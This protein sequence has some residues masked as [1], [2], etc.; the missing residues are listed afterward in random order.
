LGYL[1]NNKHLLPPSNTRTSADAASLQQAPVPSP[2][3]IDDSPVN[4]WSKEHN[5]YEGLSNFAQRPFSLD[6]VLIARI[7]SEIPNP[8]IRSA[9]TSYLREKGNAVTVNAVE[10]LFQAMKLFY[11]DKYVSNGKF[12]SEGQLLFEEILNDIPESAKRKGGRYGRVKGLDEDS[13]NS[14][15]KALMKVIAK[16][17]FDA[18]ADAKNLLLSTGK[19]PITHV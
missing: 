10:N 17:S 19:R 13:W 15:S 12:N 3:E 9:L 1:V 7:V 18:N 16:Y 11:S 5:G 14:E 8:Q 4:V 6:D 2:S